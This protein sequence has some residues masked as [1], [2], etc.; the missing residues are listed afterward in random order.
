[1]KISIITPT[2][3]RPNYLR[4]IYQLIQKQTHQDW[5][6]LIYDTSLQPV[7]FSNK[8]ITYIHDRDIVSIGQKRNRL[9]EIASG[10][11]IVHFDD[12]DYYAPTYLESVLKY[13]DG[14]SLFTLHSWFSYDSKTEQFYYWD[15]E[16][17]GEVRYC[18]N[19]ISGSSVREIDFGPH[20]QHQKEDLNQKGREGYGFSFAYT[21]EVALAFFFE[22]LD[23]AEDRLFFE[24][25]KMKGELIKTM[26][27]QKGMAIH[28]IHNSNTSAEFP[29]YR[30]PHFL[31]R[32]MLADFFAYREH[33]E[34]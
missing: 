28:V 26:P 1:M 20:L 16:E 12:D 32:D 21:K 14:F 23:V 31:L 19:A 15:T 9:K 7:Q 2:C 13:L 5:E 4:G 17:L 34:N 8:K 18:L 27:D 24:N 10:D 25:L 29:Q 6:W 11:I 30:I 33:L 3:E 22:D